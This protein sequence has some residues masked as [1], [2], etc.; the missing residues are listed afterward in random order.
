MEGVLD[1]EVGVGEAGRQ[2][3]ALVPPVGVGVR[4]GAEVPLAANVARHLGVQHGR[5]GREGRLGVEDGRQRLVLDLHERQRLLGHVGVLGGDGDD[6]LADVAHTVASEQRHVAQADADERARQVGAGEDGMDAGH[7]ARGAHVEVDDARVRVGAA[8]A[9][10]PELSGAHH[11]GGKARL[12][13]D[14]RLALD[15]SQRPTDHA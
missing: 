15:P 2:V 10:R 13:G 7:A 6:A 8:Q 14:F 11:V 1:H 12:P 9:L 4:V 3:A 5:V